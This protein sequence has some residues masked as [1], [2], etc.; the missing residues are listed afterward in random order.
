MVTLFNEVPHGLVVQ[1]RG[2]QGRDPKRYR[3]ICRPENWKGI[4]VVGAIQKIT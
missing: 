4:P 2:R 3:G 1:T